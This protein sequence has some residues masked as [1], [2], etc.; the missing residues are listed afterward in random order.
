[1]KKLISIVSTLCL[2]SSSYSQDTIKVAPSIYYLSSLNQDSRSFYGS[3]QYAREDI[4]YTD[5]LREIQYCYYMDSI[6]HCLGSTYQIK[7]NNLLLV[8]NHRDTTQWNINKLSDSLYQVHALIDGFYTHG[9]AS[10]IVPLRFVKDL[11][12]TTADKK[13]TLWYTRYEYSLHDPE[14][15]PIYTLYKS[16]ILGKVYESKQCDVPPTRRDGLSFTSIVWDCAEGC[17]ND[18]YYVVNRTTFIITSEGRIK[19][20]SEFGNL[21]WSCAAVY[22]DFLK[23]VYRNSPVLPA[24][25]KTKPINI[26]WT[27]DVTGQR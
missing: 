25:R 5:S 3:V 26:K 22:I 6:R 10:S 16:A 8:S 24:T 14:G 17:Y 15:Y 23:A 2:L 4:V 9:L 1:M 18:P 7:Q 12:T 19:N 11:I 20:I 13:D 27:V 21:D